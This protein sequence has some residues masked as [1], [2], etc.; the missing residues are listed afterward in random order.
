MSDQNQIDLK[1]KPIEAGAPVPLPPDDSGSQALTEALRSSFVIVK[2]IMVG[3]VLLF[4]GS[5]FFT[6]EPQ[7]QAI[8]LRF[9]KP[10]GEGDKALLGPGF[11]WAFPAPIDEVVKIPIT[12]IQIAS[13]TVGWYATTPEMEA[14]K[15]EPP[16]GPSLNPAIDSYALTSDAN[17]IHVRASLRY[18]ITDPIRFH[19]EFANAAGFVANALNNGLLFA[20]AHFTVDDALTRKVAAFRESVAGRVRELV[21]QQQ[22]GIAIEQIDVQPIAPRQLQ[23]KFNEVL[24][25]S[26]KRDDARNKAETY[27]NEALSKA[28]AEA[29]SRL[30]VAQ[31]ERARLVQLVAA[32]AKKFSDL[33]PQYE[34]NPELFARL[35]QT[36]T[37]GK[38]LANAQEKIFLPR[39]ADGK[40]RELRLQL[41]REPQKPTGPQP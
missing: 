27:A 5:G 4:L 20:T 3:L 33:L 30:N 40:P 11:H 13:S 19:F 8:I 6:V 7:H 1:P 35:R 41:S 26:I 21:D 9:G 14:A 39:R 22:L 31:S 28:R 12:Q 2:I 16:P 32:E 10:M 36:E 23:A 29:D 38:V 37:M 34:A 15:N 17:I 25:A 24:Q 18:R